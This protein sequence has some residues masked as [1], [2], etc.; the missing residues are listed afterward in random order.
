MQSPKRKAQESDDEISDDLAIPHSARK[1]RGEWE[2][3]ELELERDRTT[4][5]ELGVVT[6]T[7]LQQFRNEE[8]GKGYQAKHVIRQPSTSLQKISHGLP[9]KKART[10]TVDVTE[11]KMNVKLELDPRIARFLKCAAFRKF[12]KELESMR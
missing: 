6:A 7:D 4:A 10:E 8:V 11:N 5:I 1:R 9:T 2:G 3:R 12:R